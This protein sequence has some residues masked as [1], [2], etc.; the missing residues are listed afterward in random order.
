MSTLKMGPPIMRSPYISVL[1]SS[2]NYLVPKSVHFETT[3]FYGIKNEG[4]FQP[5]TILKNNNIHYD[6]FLIYSQNIL[7]TTISRSK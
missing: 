1:F 5:S 2:T 6:S 4:I 7:K 3:S